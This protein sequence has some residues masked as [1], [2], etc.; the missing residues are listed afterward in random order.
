MRHRTLKTTRGYKACKSAIGRTY[1]DGNFFSTTWPVHVR[2]RYVSTLFVCCSDRKGL[3]RVSLILITLNPYTSF[4]KNNFQN[5]FLWEWLYVKKA[6][7]HQ[8]KCNSS[9][10]L[11]FRSD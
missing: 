1:E 9:S 5:V 6:G 10:V 7:H 8:S 4:T 3:L 11:V 2:L